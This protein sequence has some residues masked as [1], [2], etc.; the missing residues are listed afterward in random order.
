MGG[1]NVTD[2]ASVNI[3]QEKRHNNLHIAAALKYFSNQWECLLETLE[4]NADS[5]RGVC[6]FGSVPGRL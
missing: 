4:I 6:L 3:C 2:L 5:V 1:E